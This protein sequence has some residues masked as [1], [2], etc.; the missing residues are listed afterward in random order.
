[1]ITWDEVVD[2]LAIAAVYDCRIADEV[3]VK[4]WLAVGQ[5]RGWTAPAAQ[6]VIV[7]HYSV[8]ADRPRIAPATISDRIAAVRRAAAES[9][10]APRLPESDPD[11]YPTWL[12]AQLA[13]HVDEVLDRWAGHGQ[14]PPRAVIPAQTTTTLDDLAAAAP[15][16]VRAGIREATLRIEA[17]RTPE[18]G[19]SPR[20]AR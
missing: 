20:E 14:D 6:R 13:A 3:D 2:L 15:P 1:M 7:E 12:R 5:L 18:A 16:Q 10:E 8:G 9:F 11:H 17:R 19:R 4:A